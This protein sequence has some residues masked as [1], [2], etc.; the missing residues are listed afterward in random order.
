MRLSV[1]VPCFNEE[2]NVGRVVTQ[3]VEVGR[4]LCRELEI[5]VVN[6]G[7][8]D[9]TAE[10]LRALRS[11]FPELEVV[12]HAQNR[13]YGAAVRSGIDRAGMDYVFLT[14]GD[15]QFDLQELS[16]ALDML[17]QHDVIAGYR[18]LRR[19]GWWRSLW[20][21]FW[22]AL[23]NRFLGLDVRDA[24]CAFKLVPRSLLSS[25]ELRSD[26]A[27]ISAELLLEA[28]RS[29]L[30]IG[31]LAVRHYPRTAGRQT[32]ASPRVVLTAFRELFGLLVRTWRSRVA[33]LSR[34]TT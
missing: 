19:D 6:D 10:V 13:G 25:T 28:R 8:T 33:A 11:E 3:A 29:E 24:N 21:R 5:V 22:T 1:V 26:G 20:G 34:T 32:G 30:R 14:D 15:G 16:G 31:E 12:T 9:D 18:A 7:S 23:V 4:R 2:G 17:D 27:L